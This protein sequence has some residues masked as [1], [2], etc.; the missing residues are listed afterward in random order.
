MKIAKFIVNAIALS[1]LLS[2][3]Q[4]N[5]NSHS[6]QVIVF[7]RHGE[8]PNPATCSL[9]QIDCQGLN[10]AMALPQILNKKFGKPDYIFAPD[11][12]FQIKDGHHCKELNSYVRPLATI[13]PTAIHYSMPVATPLGFEEYSGMAHILLSP[14]YRHSLIFVAWESKKLVQIIKT[15]IEILGENSSFIPNWNRDDFDSLYVLNINWDNEKGTPK[16]IHDYESLNDQSNVCFNPIINKS[17]TGISARET[18]FIIPSAET[19]GFAQLSCAGL[20][21][22]LALQKVLVSSNPNVGMEIDTFIA[23]D[24]GLMLFPISGKT[25]YYQRALMTLEPTAISQTKPLWTLFGYND[26]AGVAAYLSRQEFKNKTV[27]IAWDASE[28]PQLAQLLY[29]KAKGD[30]EKVPKI[31]P[32]LNTI[33]KITIEEGKPPVFTS[34]SERISAFTGCSYQ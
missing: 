19:N 34:F 14:E 23:A 24:P 26:S 11:P 13:E 32:D 27:A 20:N 16:F 22:S 29:I 9:G 31:P 12:F 18:I 3:C 21:R 6:K 1:L 30:G 28:I 7:M 25:Y 15:I 33:Y 10:R 17:K 8:K 5:K 2:G 4:P